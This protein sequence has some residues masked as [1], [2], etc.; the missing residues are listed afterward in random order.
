ML[1]TVI[2]TL[3]AIAGIF[4]FQHWF[5]NFDRA[6]N[7][8]QRNKYSILWHAAQWFA[9]AAIALIFI[10]AYELWHYIPLLAA[11]MTLWWWGFDGYKGLKYGHGFLY[12]G[13][14]DGST[15]E[16]A[17]NWIAQ[18]WTGHFPSFY[19][20]V[21]ISITFIVIAWNIAIY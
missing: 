8:E 10:S 16:I 2:F 11:A 4:A 12:A 13:D 18:K 21:K 1:L 3:T 5:E 17:L 14:G 19:L 20:F 9:L 7:Q 6:E 15:I